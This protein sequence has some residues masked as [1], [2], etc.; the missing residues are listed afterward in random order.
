[1]EIFHKEVDSQPQDD[2]RL[3]WRKPEFQHLTITIDTAFGGSSA[4]D[5]DG[6]GFGF[7][8]LP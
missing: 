3:P 2:P 6:L 8:K 1:M 7:T 4:P 5:G